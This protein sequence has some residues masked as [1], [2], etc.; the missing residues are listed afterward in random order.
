MLKVRCT[1][2]S[3]VAFLP[4]LVMFLSD[5]LLVSSKSAVLV[6]GNRHQY[7]QSNP[8][9]AYVLCACATEV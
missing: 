7:F 3:T 4:W 2:E 8:A 6:T 1:A 5:C 9:F